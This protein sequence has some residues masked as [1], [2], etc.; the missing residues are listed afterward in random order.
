MERT[1]WEA[2]TVLETQDAWRGGFIL[3][4]LR[5]VLLPHQLVEEGASSKWWVESIKAG[6]SG[7][8]FPSAPALF[9]WTRMCSIPAAARIFSWVCWKD[10]G[11]YI[12][13]V[14][15]KG[16]IKPSFR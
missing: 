11:S 15:G 13:P 1:V 9:L 12:V 14:L 4:C 8:G 10:S 3:F 7:Q 5:R 2:Y 16:N 6:R